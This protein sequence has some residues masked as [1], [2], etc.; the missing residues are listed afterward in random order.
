MF[1]SL[2]S[3]IFLLGFFAFELAQN[4]FRACIKLILSMLKIDFQQGGK[5]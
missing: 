3:I 2:I 1:T 4:Q 5:K